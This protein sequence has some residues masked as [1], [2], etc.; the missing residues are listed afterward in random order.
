MKEINLRDYQLASVDGL[1]TGIASGHNAQMLCAPTGAGKGVMAAH[2]VAESRR[3][4]SRTAVVV[5][6][7]SLVDQISAT[8]DQY[9]IDHGVIQSQH[10]RFRPHEPTQIISTGTLARRDLSRMPPFQLLIWDE[11]HIQIKAVLDMMAANPQMRVVGLSATP[12]SK[13]LGKIYSNIVNVTTTNRLIADGWLSPLKVYAARPIDMTGA[14]L[15]FDGE[16]EPTE[17]EKRSIEITG[18]IVS[19]WVA[20]TNQYFGGPVKTIVFSATVAHGEE[21]CKQFQAI[22]VNVQQ[23]SYKDGNDDR[24]RALIEE[25]RKPD[26][27]IHGLVSCEALGRGFDVPDIKCMVAARPYRKAFSSWIQQIGRGMRPHPGKDYCVLLDHSSNFIRFQAD[28]ED[29]FANGIQSLDDSDLDSKVRKEPEKKESKPCCEGCGY[30]M[31]AADAC[32]PSCGKD[33]PQR[34]S[35]VAHVPGELTEVGKA[36]GKKLLDWMQDKAQV[37]REIWGFALERKRGDVEAASRFAN[38]QYRNFYDEWPHRAFR[39]IE[40]AFPTRKV[41]DKIKRG[42]IKYFRAKAAA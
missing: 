29:F 26:S 37:Q 28:M 17:I 6:R 35:D 1:R 36:N 21:L 25:F 13:G 5:D 4:F 7:I 14:K 15:K 3:K 24:R 2:L 18:D 8:F 42:L 9:G 33:R 27:E 20:K 23:V 41:E 16:W 31:Q 32:C 34:K 38:A 40:P 30:V 10:W 19:G 11:A 39:G 22:G 12:F